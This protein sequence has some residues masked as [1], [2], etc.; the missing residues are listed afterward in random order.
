MRHNQVAGGTPTERLEPKRK[1]ANQNLPKTPAFNK[2]RRTPSPLRCETRRI[3]VAPAPGP[4]KMS[5]PLKEEMPCWPG[6]SE[7]CEKPREFAVFHEQREAE[8]PF[9]YLCSVYI[10]TCSAHLPLALRRD[11]TAMNFV[12]PYEGAYMNPQIFA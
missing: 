1:R 7:N 6:Q 2:P 5:N 8:L 10:G 4:I 11:P 9:D 3:E 12:R